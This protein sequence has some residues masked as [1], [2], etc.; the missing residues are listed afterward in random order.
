MNRND[1]NLTYL[2]CKNAPYLFKWIS[3]CTKMYQKMRNFSNFNLCKAKKYPKK[4]SK[5]VLMLIF[6]HFISKRYQKVQFCINLRVWPNGFCHP[7]RPLC[8]GRL[9][10]DKIFCLWRLKCSETHTTLHNLFH[11]LINP[12]Y[13]FNM[14]SAQMGQHSTFLPW[15]TMRRNI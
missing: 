8:T 9:R 5:I 6:D 12:V 3:I 14:N 13:L 2:A 1:W 11:F 10:D 7:L 15:Q 4:I